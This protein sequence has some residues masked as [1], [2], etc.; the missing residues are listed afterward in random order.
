MMISMSKSATLHTEISEADLV[1]QCERTT[2]RIPHET[3]AEV[4]AKYRE[5][6]VQ[7][8]NYAVNSPSPE[9]L[10]DMLRAYLLREGLVLCRASD[11]QYGLDDSREFETL[12]DIGALVKGA[13]DAI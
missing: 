5:G 6:S 7:P 2:Q 1:L 3:L 11:T 8:A 9:A 4:Q 13:L 10:A 12:R